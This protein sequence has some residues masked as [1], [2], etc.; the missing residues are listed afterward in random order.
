QNPRTH[1]VAPA[2]TPLPLPRARPVVERLIGLGGECQH[3]RPAAP[4]TGAD[5]PVWASGVTSSSYAFEPTTPC[6]PCGRPLPRSRRGPRVCPRPTNP[7]LAFPLRRQLPV[8]SE[9]RLAGELQLRGSPGDRLGRAAAARRSS[10]HPRGPARRPPQPAAAR[11]RAC[12]D[13]LG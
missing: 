3:P 6:P 4:T 9:P 12:H 5:N 11:E 8:T 1:L 13:D 2:P 7:S 10:A